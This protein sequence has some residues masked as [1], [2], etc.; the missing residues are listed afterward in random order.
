M[1]TGTGGIAVVGG[2]VA[3]IRCVKTLRQFGYSDRVVLIDRDGEDPYDKPGLS[4]AFLADDTRPAP[5][6]AT[7]AELRQW[8]VEYRPGTAAIGLDTAGPKLET[9]AGL[10]SFDSVVVATGCQP[11]PLPAAATGHRIGYLRSLDSARDLRR[12]I[13]PGAYLVVVGGGFLGLE[14]AASVRAR[15]ATVTVIEA[16]DRLLARGVPTAVAR[17][18]EGRHRS[19]GVDLRLETTVSAVHEQSDEVQIHLS[20]GGCV[21]ADYVLVAIGADPV[22]DWVTSS[23]LLLDNGILCDASMR[24]SA[25]H[26][27]AVGDCASFVNPLF[28]RRMRLE[29]WT[30]AGEQAAFV[31]RTLAG[32]SRSSS[33]ELLPY[34]WSDQYDLHIQSVGVAGRTDSTFDVGAHGLLSLACEGAD[35]V[36]ATAVNG[37]AALLRIR[38]ALRDGPI[39]FASLESSVLQNPA[40]DIRNQHS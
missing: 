25:E 8:S 9:D 4:K 34:V 39:A 30:S 5:Q 27:Y 20:D 7:A 3:G 6:L 40:L 38:T 19:H 29:H 28:G 10:E 36:G 15:G 11:R 21:T 24:T 23:N 26:V 16:G 31:A 12:H 32:R 37:Q 35:I 1:T 13:R 22:V 2:S 33:C 14:V 18:V 17:Y